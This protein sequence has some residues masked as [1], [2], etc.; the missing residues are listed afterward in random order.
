[1]VTDLE[2]MAKKLMSKKLKNHK[3][4]VE[5][6]SPS[7]LEEATTSLAPGKLLITDIPSGI[8]AEMLELFI[9]GV[10]ELQSEN[11]YT[12]TLKLPKAQMLL[13]STHSENGESI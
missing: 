9:D 1:M 4:I 11:D 12:L 13:S 3:L 5:P 2:E 8:G 6:A 7:T 10:L